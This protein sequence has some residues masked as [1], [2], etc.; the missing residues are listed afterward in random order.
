MV[1]AIALPFSSMAESSEPEPLSPKALEWVKRGV[2]E[3]RARQRPP[4]CPTA[5]QP[6]TDE[7]IEVMR[8]RW[9]RG[10]TLFHADDPR[11]SLG[12]E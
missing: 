3:Q 10:E 5:T 2:R 6:G 4:R 9:E 11:N 7:K 12:R 1:P 8:Q